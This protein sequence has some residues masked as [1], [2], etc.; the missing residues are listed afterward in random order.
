MI[1]REPFDGSLTPLDPEVTIASSVYIIKISEQG[2]KY[3][4]AITVTLPVLKPFF[5]W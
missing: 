3:L 4:R 2:V 1:T 5:D